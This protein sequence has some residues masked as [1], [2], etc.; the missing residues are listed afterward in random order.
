MRSLLSLVTLSILS[1][2]PAQASWIRAGDASTVFQGTGPAGFKLEGKTSE[3]TV[4]DNGDTLL[5]TVPLKTLDTGIGLRNRHM[6]EKYIEVDKHPDATL[7][8]SKAALKLPTADATT[9]GEVPGVFTVR[10]KSKEVKVLYKLDCK[11]GTCQVDGDFAINLRD[12]DIQIPSYL[13][14]T[15]KPDMTVKTRFGAKDDGAAPKSN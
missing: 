14:V 9:S 13:G 2:L 4:Q 15:V 10:G 6:R 11:A 5:F 8:V 12:Y 3:L 7:K 1:A